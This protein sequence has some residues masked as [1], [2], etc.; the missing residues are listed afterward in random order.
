MPASIALLIV[1][2]R[3]SPLS[4]EMAMPS[5]FWVMN[6]SRISFCFSWSAVV[7]RVPEDVDVAVFLRLPLGADLRV[8]EDRNVERLRD[9]GEPQPLSRSLP[10]LLARRDRRHLRIH[11]SP[12]SP[13]LAASHKPDRLVHQVLAG[14]TATSL[15]QQQLIHDDDHDDHQADDQPI[16]ERRARESAAA[17]CAARRRSACRAPRR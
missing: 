17:R 14:L 10:A 7:G 12:R 4:A 2:V 13:A 8:V 9:H 3:K 16:V 6:D 1:S 5:T 11:R 15:L